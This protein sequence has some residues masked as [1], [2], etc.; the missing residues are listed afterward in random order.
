MHSQRQ[1]RVIVVEPRSFEEV[2]DYRQYQNKRPVIVNLEQAEA[3]WRR[4]V[5][6]ISGATYFKRQYAKVGSGIFLIQQHGYLCR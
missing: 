5:D 2:R 1:I 6:F 3:N 4:V